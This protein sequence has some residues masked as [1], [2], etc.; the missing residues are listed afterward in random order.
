MSDKT[1][2][3]AIFYGPNVIAAGTPRELEY[4]NGEYQKVVVIDFTDDGVTAHR[5][6]RIG[7]QTEE[8]IPYRFVDDEHDEPDGQAD[9]PN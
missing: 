1:T 6:F 7:H 2:Y 3:Q 8:P 9:I 4:V 5:T